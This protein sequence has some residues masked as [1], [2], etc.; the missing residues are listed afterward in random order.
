VQ[1]SSTSSS[2][3]S[4]P[5]TRAVTLPIIGDLTAAVPVSTSREI[6]LGAA[7]FVGAFFVVRA[8]VVLARNTSRTAS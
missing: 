8:G 1:R 4:R 7:L 2:P 3:S 6:K 5:L